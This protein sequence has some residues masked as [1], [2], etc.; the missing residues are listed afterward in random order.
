MLDRG[1][2]KKKILSVEKIPKDFT[3]QKK[4]LRC[5]KYNK[6]KNMPENIQFCFGGKN[7]DRELINMS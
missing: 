3:R 2:I 5:I 6:T 4:R 1:K 7:D